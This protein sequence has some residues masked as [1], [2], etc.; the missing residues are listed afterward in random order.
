MDVIC[1]NIIR[2][3][4][5]WGSGDVAYYAIALTPEACTCRRVRDESSPS[6]LPVVLF[7]LMN[8]I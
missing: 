3:H 6:G 4:L 7:S 8:F 2:K 1:K 5:V